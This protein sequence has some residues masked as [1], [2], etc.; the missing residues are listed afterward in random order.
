MSD[1]REDVMSRGASFGED[2]LVCPWC[3]YEDPDSSEW[4]PEHHGPEGDGTA[5]CPSCGEDFY[6]SRHVQWT[7]STRRKP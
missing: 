6:C 2:N 3:G 4:Q 1:P 7:Y 5:M